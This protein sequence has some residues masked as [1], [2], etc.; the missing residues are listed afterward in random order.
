VVHA[1]AA[2]DPAGDDG[3]VDRRHGRACAVPVPDHGELPAAGTRARRKGRE[4]AVVRVTV[5]RHADRYF[6]GAL[7]VD[8]KFPTIKL[9]DGK[10]VTLSPGAYQLLLQT[11]YNQAD[12]AKAFD[13]M[14]RTYA[15]TANTYGAIYNS[16]L[17]KDWFTAQARNY[18]TTLAAALDTDAVPPA[19]VENLTAAVRAGTAP[20]QRF[21]KLRKKLLGLDSYHLYDGSIPCT[22]PTRRI[23]T[24][25]RRTS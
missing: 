16:V 22:R 5:Q 24:T 12:R 13:S 8:I 2:E 10:E 23:R 18:P 4:A 11:N 9:A 19:V 20:L 3:E 25:S 6:P 14:I 1:G 17:Q 15:A 21:V 7:D